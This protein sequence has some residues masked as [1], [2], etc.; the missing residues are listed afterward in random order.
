MQ[1]Y[2][3]FIFILLCSRVLSQK[4]SSQHLLGFLFSVNIGKNGNKEMAFKKNMICFDMLS[5]LPFPIKCTT[6]GHTLL[7]SW[8]KGHIGQKIMHVPCSIY[9]EVY[10]EKA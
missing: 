8:V 6:Q 9:F 7:L 2:H 5:A 3:H 1:Y 10:A 4:S